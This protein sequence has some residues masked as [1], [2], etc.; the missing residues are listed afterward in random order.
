MLKKKYNTLSINSNNFEKMSRF[1]TKN[2]FFSIILNIHFEF[3]FFSTL[4]QYEIEK[5]DKNFVI[6]NMISIEIEILI[7]NKMN[8]TFEFQKRE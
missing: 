8:S 4:E 6:E 3:V 7:E 2:F 1:D 5:I